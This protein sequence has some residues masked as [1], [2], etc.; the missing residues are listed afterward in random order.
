M[1]P[2]NA[3]RYLEIA[4]G[5]LRRCIEYD[6]VL[7]RQAPET[8]SPVL[9][10]VRNQ[11]IPNIAGYEVLAFLLNGSDRYKPNQWRRTSVRQLWRF[12][13]SEPNL[14]PLLTAEFFSLARLIGQKPP[15]ARR[16]TRDD[17]IQ[18]LQMLRM[19]LDRVLLREIYRKI[20]DDEEPAPSRYGRR[21]Y[22]RPTR[23]PSS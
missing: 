5:D 12:W 20:L 22:G 4:L 9:D 14:H 13:Q 16:L 2:G 15:S 17:R 3:E 11:F 19:P 7:D 1:A 18:G 10:A 23:T 6:L 21:N 8:R